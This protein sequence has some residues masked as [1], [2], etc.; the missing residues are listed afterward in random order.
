MTTYLNAEKLVYAFTEARVFCEDV[1]RELDAATRLLTDEADMWNGAARSH[2]L[3]RVEDIK[4]RIATLTT[5]L[6]NLEDQW[7]AYAR[8]RQQNLR[9]VA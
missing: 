1:T 9:G 6:T 5:D 2:D 3:K 4:T 8:Q 7:A